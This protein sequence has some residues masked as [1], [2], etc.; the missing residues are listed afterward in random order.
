MKSPRERKKSSEETGL[1]TGSWSHRSQR[2]QW[3][4]PDNSGVGPPHCSPDPS[5]SL[6]RPG[7]DM[8]DGNTTECLQ[9]PLSESLWVIRGNQEECFLPARKRDELQKAPRTGGCR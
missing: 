7:L 9:S 8:K 2:D 3:L 1:K 4:L 5:V 6:E